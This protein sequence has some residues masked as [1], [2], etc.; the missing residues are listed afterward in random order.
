MLYPKEDKERRILL[1]AV[2]VH[3][4]DMHVIQESL[5]VRIVSWVFL[6]MFHL[7]LIL[8]TFSE[9]CYNNISNSSLL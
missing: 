3:R 1:Y 8:T 2:S 6:K 7:I 9:S 5:A 4:I